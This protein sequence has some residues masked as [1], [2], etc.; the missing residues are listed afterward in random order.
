MIEC[1]M[2]ALPSI[3]NVDEERLAEEKKVSANCRL[4]GLKHD[5]DDDGGLKRSV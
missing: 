5:E 2:E 4:L 1:A 3:F